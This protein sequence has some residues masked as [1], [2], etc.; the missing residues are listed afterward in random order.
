MADPITNN[1]FLIRKADNLYDVCEARGHK[2]LLM[3]INQF[4]SPIIYLAGRSPSTRTFLLGKV[5]GVVEQIKEGSKESTCCSPERVKMHE[6]MFDDLREGEKGM[7]SLFI[8]DSSS[9]YGYYYRQDDP[10][11]ETII[12][13]TLEKFIKDVEEQPE[14]T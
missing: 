14:L 9:G 11:S 10:F 4:E 6:Q 5:R 12:K 1:S 7:F 2:G 13:D 3:I 8:E